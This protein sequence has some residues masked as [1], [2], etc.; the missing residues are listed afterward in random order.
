MINSIKFTEGYGYVSSTYGSGDYPTEPRKSSYESGWGKN[1]KFDTERYNEDMKIYEKRLKEAKD[2]DGSYKLPELYKNLIDRTI[3][4]DP[5]KINIIF[6]P[7]GSGKTTI[8]KA[9]AGNA[10]CFDGFTELKEPMNFYKGSHRKEEDCEKLLKDVIQN[11]RKNSCEIDWTGSPIYYE[12]FSGR[13][14]RSSGYIGDLCGGFMS[15]VDEVRYIIA[16][17]Q[18]CSSNLSMIPLSGVLDIFK[19]GKPITYSQILQKTIESLESKKFNDTW[20][21]CYQTQVEYFMG[22]PDSNNESPNTILFDEP[23]SSFDI[24]TIYKF[25]KQVFKVMRER[26]GNS[27]IISI[28][29]SPI[30]FLPEI[31]ESEDYNIISMDQG[32][33]DK[34]IEILRKSL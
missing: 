29:H 19:K 2:R 24:L 4:F 34:C 15:P 21:K 16:R 25:Y 23:D 17:D 26:T 3:T 18:C 30:I 28:T 14:R 32:Y 8:I 22:F 10:L 27:Q 11:E 12:N 9:L 33:T 7:N 1:C 6:G 13:S 20:R 5:H 31:W